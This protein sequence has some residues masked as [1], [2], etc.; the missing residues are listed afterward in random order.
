MPSHAFSEETV[1]PAA[2]VG[3]LVHWLESAGVHC[4][5]GVLLGT[6][7]A[8]AMRARHLHWSWAAGA[9]AISV[10]AR[11]VH[12]G[13]MLTLA[14]ASLLA[15]TRGRRWHREDLEA[16][17]DLAEI[18]SRRRRPLD[19]LRT[20]ALVAALR[21]R[22]QLGAERW[23]RRG[24]ELLLG[25]DESHHGVSIP[26]GGEGGGTHTLVVGAT[27]SGKTVTQTWIAVRA[28]EHGMGTVV[29]DPKGDRDMR[30]ELRRGALAAGRSFLEWTPA[31]ARVYNPYAHG[32][33]SEIADKVL[34]GE[35][36]TEP[37]YQRQAQRYLGHVVRALRATG[38]QASLRAIVEQLEPTRLELLAREL[39]E[40]DARATFSYLDS[41]SARQHSELA[42]VR[43]RLSILAESD[44]GRWLDP[45]T[46]DVEQFDLLAAVNRRAV[47]YFNLEADSRPLLSEMLGAAIV[48][49]L[50]TT[51][52]SLQG[53]P[54][55]TL[56]VIDEFSAI[57]AEQVVRLFGRAR[58]AGFS[59]LLGTQELS[60]LRPPGRERLLEQVLGNLSVLIAHRQVV[61]DSAELIANIAGRRGTWKVSRHSEG[62]STRARTRDF[63]LDPNR[64]MS[65]GRGWAAVLVLGDAGRTRVARM[66]SPAR[67]R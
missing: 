22:E 65:L 4:I 6:L 49:D 41:L 31:G 42:G 10:L 12:G 29:V 39:P 7:A 13:W 30:E 8:R 2:T 23:L 32:G 15:T 21:M 36:F 64:V 24:H 17:M 34:A 67:R 43:D 26:F 44:V 16:G 56:V 52:A 53:R 45:Q 48:Q 28:I 3:E 5:L 37:H 35:R 1:D 50:Q 59:L 54:V 58:S 33:V 25:F 14:T 38:S 47:V 46:T 18:A 60:D 57:A 61:P 66:L 20:L 40:A 19:L 9:L 51:V 55:P 11:P 63:V 27:G 62:S